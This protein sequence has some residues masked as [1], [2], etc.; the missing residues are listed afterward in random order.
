MSLTLLLLILFKILILTKIESLY[1]KNSF[2][3]IFR[4]TENGYHN[5]KLKNIIKL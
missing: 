1:L 3:L 5:H 4:F 2:Y